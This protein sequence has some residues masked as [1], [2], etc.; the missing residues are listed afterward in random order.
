MYCRIVQLQARRQALKPAVRAAAL[1]VADVADVGGKPAA[2]LRPV[3]AVELLARVEAN[4][5]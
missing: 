4:N 1:V 5:S 3:P 2:Q